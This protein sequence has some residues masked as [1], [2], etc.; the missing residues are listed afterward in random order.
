MRACTGALGRRGGPGAAGVPAAGRGGGPGAGPGGPAAAPGAGPGGPG[1]RGG[2]G[3]GGRGGG[4]PR[5]GGPGLPHP[6]GVRRRGRAPARPCRCLC[7]GV[8]AVPGRGRAALPG[9]ARRWRRRVRAAARG[10]A[11]PFGRRGRRGPGPRRAPGAGGRRG[12]RG[13]GVRPGGRPGGGPGGGRA[14]A[15]GGEPARGGRGAGVRGAVRGGG[16]AGILRA[17]RDAAAAAAGHAAA[18]RPRGGWGGVPRRRGDAR[19]RGALL[20]QRGGPPVQVGRGRQAPVRDQGPERPDGERLPALPRGA[21]GGGGAGRRPG[22]H[23]GPVR[24]AAGDPPRAPEPQGPA[25][26]GAVRQ[27]SRLAALGA[28]PRRLP[29]PARIRAGGRPHRRRARGAD[30]ARVQPQAPAGGPRGQ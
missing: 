13:A 19:A 23:R 27:A 6:H 17:K 21:R 14:R 28:V 4:V 18:A 25:G 22:A 5:P 12:L 8:L 15:A 3:R 29:Q 9:R 10:R 7:A 30:A 16:G 11:V 2:G 26:G 1:G 20:P 24:G